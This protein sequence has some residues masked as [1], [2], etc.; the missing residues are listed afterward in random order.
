MQTGGRG[1]FLSSNITSG[2]VTPPVACYDNIV[3]MLFGAEN[4]LLY[5]TCIF[6]RGVATNPIPYRMIDSLTLTS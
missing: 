6:N 4:I 5:F 3:K 1:H 2:A